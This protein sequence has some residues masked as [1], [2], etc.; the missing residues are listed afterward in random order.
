[1]KVPHI[2]YI[3]A[4]VCS[5]LTRD[6]IYDRLSDQEFFITFEGVNQVHSMLAQINPDYITNNEP[7]PGWLMEMGVDKMVSYIRKLEMPRGVAGIDGAFKILE[8]PLMYRLVTSLA[9]AK[10]TDEDIELIVNG[11]Y[12]ISY[13]PEDI[14]E[15]LHYFFNVKSWSLTDKVQYIEITETV[16]L[17]KFYKLALQ[18]DKDKLVWKLGVAPNKSFDSML[19]E[20]MIDSFYNFKEHAKV[21]ADVAQKWGTLALKTVEKLEK[22][23]RDTKDKKDLFKEISFELNNNKVEGKEKKNKSTSEGPMSKET[24]K[25]KHI[26]EL[27]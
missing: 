27:N 25:I 4:L 10:I 14:T 19:R 9:I 23:D 7:D 24:K 3:E 15:F 26:S 5:K 8:D 11:K 6:Q 20:I 22:F 21:N 16:E 2:K 1:M 12:N 18:G 17:K 13:T